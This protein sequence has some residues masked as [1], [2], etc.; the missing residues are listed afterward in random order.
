M[1]SHTD[2]QIFG[3]L[4]QQSALDDVQVVGIDLGLVRANRVLPSAQ[5]GDNGLHVEVT[6]LHDTHLD[7]STAAG[8][9][10][11]RKL[12]QLGLESPCVRQVRLHHDTGGVGEELWLRQYFLEETHG[13]MGVLILLHVEVD[14]LGAL[15]A[16]FV[17]VGIVDGSLVEFRHTANKFGERLLIVERVCLGV[18][19]RNLHRDIV[20]V[21]F[22]KSLEIAVVALVGFLV[23]EHHLTEQVDV[24]AN[25][26]VETCGK[27]IGEVRT[28][29]VDDDA[30]G[31]H[32]KAL[33]DD[34]YGNG[35]EI[36][37]ER[38][39]H[40]E[41]EA[42]ASVEKLGHS[43]FVDEGL[44]ALGEFLGVAYLR[45][46]VEHLH[47]ELLVAGS[48]HHCCI[49]VLF[50]SF[51]RRDA[52]LAGVIQRHQPLFYFFYC[53]LFHIKIFVCLV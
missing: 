12:E 34:G 9:T 22:L 29:S 7:R 14:K 42:V 4:G 41:Q 52:C 47:Q 8:A 11:L 43:I 19:T 26:L 20:D 10:L 53:W 18:D 50:C 44:D 2:V 16:V 48:L 5:R 46:L 17:N 6:A 49:L 30:R 40:L 28:C 45:R 33:L 39:V 3:V 38:L 36:V 15:L 1:R 24:L 37:T 25:L 31:V 21:R 32:A 13:Q 35:I 27:V 51:G 23:S